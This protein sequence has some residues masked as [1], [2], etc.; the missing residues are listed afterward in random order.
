MNQRVLTTALLASLL[1]VTAG[2]NENKVAATGGALAVKVN[3]EAISAE[4]VDRELAKAGESLKS[5]PPNTANQVLN[6]LVEQRLLV[7][8]AKKSGVDKDPKVVQALE[9][10]KNQILAQAYL[11][12]S[13]DS[14][15]KPGDTE[16]SEFH[17]KHPE[18]FAERRVYRLQE[19][20]IQVTPE[21]QAAVKS[22]LSA[23]ANMGE[24]VNWL[25][26]Q[27]IPVRGN[28]VVRGAD[29]LPMD[30]AARLHKLN[31]GQAV[32]VEG[33]KQVSVLVITGIQSQPV[34]LEQARPAIERLLMNN[35]KRD[36]AKADLDKLRGAAKI[37]FVEPFAE[38]KAAA[39]HAVSAPKDEP[40]LEQGVVDKALS[41]LK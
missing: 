40:P 14:A 16:I 13:T 26:S 6:L 5:V 22:R 28:E 38:A 23:G 4:E 33:P 34:S 37:E 19:L 21:N 29:Q 41:G 9:A 36:L 31:V 20:G 1:L 27:N 11:A 8:Q 17:A 12:K 25:K 7:Q 3:G 39:G 2:C 24:L 10:A 15:A 32:T 18:L 30:M 35:K